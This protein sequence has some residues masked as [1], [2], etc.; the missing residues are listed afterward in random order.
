MAR[1]P[2]LEFA[3]AC[4]HVLNRGN[5]RGDLFET[6]GAAQAFV[7][8][9]G[10][11]SERMGWRVHAYCVMRN[12]YHLALET[13]RGNLVSGV[14]W[15][16]STFGN[17]FNRYRGERGRAFQG[18]YQAILV[19]AGVHLG[20]L[21]DYIHLNPVRAGIV[22]LEQLE[23]FRWSSLR[24][25]VNPTTDQPAWL[26][27]E[28]W[29]RTRGLTDTRDGW[30]SYREH[31]NWLMA[32]ESRQKAA[33]EGMSKGWA[34]G[35]E[36]FKRSLQKNFREKTIARDWGGEEI[37]ELNRM[38]WQDLLERGAAE[39]GHLLIGARSTAKSASWKIALASWMKTSCS[40]PNRWLSE[41]LHMGA[42]DAVS[43]YVAEVTNGKRPSAALLLK[44]LTTNSRG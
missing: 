21:V 20:Q 22:R 42:P 23:Q 11:A 41:Q 10:E 30:E 29:M 7:D 44:R 13:P 37:A 25:F 12:H 33:F 40:V 2:R 4:Y 34:I 18:R 24:R 31:L 3:G 27:C 14:H 28:E 8:C 15:L 39:I 19:E 9:L 35:S 5:Y 43:R 17:R 32:D 36:S 6:T 38:H 16:Q 26:H 1:K